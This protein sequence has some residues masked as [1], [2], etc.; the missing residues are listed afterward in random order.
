MLDEYKRKRNFK[1]TPEPDGINN[2]NKKE[3][4]NHISNNPNSLRTN[5]DL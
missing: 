5:L 3:S 2:L 1:A 4:K